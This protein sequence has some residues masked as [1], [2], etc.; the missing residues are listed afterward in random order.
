MRIISTLTAN[1]SIVILFMFIFSMPALLFPKK[2]NAKDLILE[3]I[4]ISIFAAL[5]IIMQVMFFSA[6]KEISISGTANKLFWLMLGLAI[7]SVALNSRGVLS[8]FKIEVKYLAM[9]L[10]PIFPV[11]LLAARSG[12]T[13]P[14][15]SSMNNDIASYAGTAEAFGETGWENTQTISSFN[16]NEFAQISSP[17]GTTSLLAFFSK[18][19]SLKSFEITTA[20]MAV[21]IV[22]NLLCGAQLYRSMHRERNTNFL[23]PTLVIAFFCPIMTYVIANYFLG[24]IFCLGICLLF[25]SAV[26]EL[27]HN[28]KTKQIYRIQIILSVSNGIYLYPVF[29]IPFFLFVLLTLSVYQIYKKESDIKTILQPYLGM[30]LG[31]IISATY[32]LT[33]I[34]ILNS[35]ANATAGWK[36]PSLNMIAILLFPELIGI[37]F[38][39]L[40]V[41]TTWIFFFTLLALL[42]FRLKHQNNL[43]IGYLSFVALPIFLCTAFMIYSKNGIADYKIWKLITFL[44]PIMLLYLVPLVASYAKYGFVLVTIIATLAASSPMTTWAINAKSDAIMTKD[45]ENLQHLKELKPYR[46]LNIKL[47]NYFESMAMASML[48]DK[49]LFINNYTYWPRTYKNEACTIMRYD[50]VTNE[51]ILKILNQTYVLVTVP[52]IECKLT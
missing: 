22:I 23:V 52:N 24:Q 17:F 49:I 4:L 1:Y 14:F 5:N 41:L 18:V 50:Q 21:A 2:N 12:L 11:L 48:N 20:T 35:Q 8:I 30:L 28:T 42:F 32:V 45:M 43:V 33:A 46:E 51:K 34:K 31:V 15:S 16:L 36:L 40:A 9:S 27:S 47:G 6:Q 44:L 29:T 10:V 13:Y 26:I 7:T 37:E 3:K 39:S 19:L 38:S 25:L